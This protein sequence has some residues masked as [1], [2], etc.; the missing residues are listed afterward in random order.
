MSPL[1]AKMAELEARFL[2]RLPEERAELSVS[3]ADD[4]REGIVERAH[5]LAGIAG[6]LGAAEL[7]DAARELEE[8]ARAG[9][10]FAE[11]AERLLALMDHSEQI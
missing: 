10:A 1:E 3:L 7:G 4:D 8:V 2:S 6:M 9:G 5:K 11:A